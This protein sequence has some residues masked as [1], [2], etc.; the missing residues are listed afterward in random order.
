M[1]TMAKHVTKGYYFDTMD[2]RYSD[3]ANRG[4]IL[5]DLRAEV[6]IAQIGSVQ[7]A[8]LE[9]QERA[10]QS[11]GESLQTTTQKRQNH[12]DRHWFGFGT[13]PW[14][15]ADFPPGNNV[16]IDP[17]STGW[18]QNWKGE[19]EPTMRCTLIRALEMAMG[20]PHWCPEHGKKSAGIPPATDPSHQ[21]R[22]RFQLPIE[23]FWVC[24]VTRFEGHIYRNARQ[25]TVIFI[26][27]GFPVPIEEYSS[28]PPHLLDQHVSA[29]DPGR[30]NNPKA[31]SV[32]VGQ[33]ETFLS[34]LNLKSVV[35]MKSGVVTHRVDIEHGGVSKTFP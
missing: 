18:W 33:D 22:A 24:G 2:H 20:L 26:T 35:T 19:P 27:P 30:P 7:A 6:A 8:P 12:L 13:P 4:Q 10:K 15:E 1:T 28:D 14:T 3:V 5:D 9:S 32:F 34:K 11:L 25:V 23:F 16:P 31:I 21:S 29:S 17:E